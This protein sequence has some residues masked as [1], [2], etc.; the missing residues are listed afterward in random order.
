VLR[1][2]TGLSAQAAEPEC[3][4]ARRI[5]RKP[6]DFLCGSYDRLGIIFVRNPRD[7]PLLWTND[8]VREALRAI[9]A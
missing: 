5:R 2:S 1:L 6:A 7:N 3:P 4:V 9:G 8:C